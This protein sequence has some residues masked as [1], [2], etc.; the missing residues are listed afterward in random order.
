MEILQIV[1]DECGISLE[2]L[3]F[4]LSDTSDLKAHIAKGHIAMKDGK[5]YITQAGADELM[6]QTFDDVREYVKDT[7]DVS[8]VEAHEKWEMETAMKGGA[9]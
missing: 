2:Q 6:S 7:E 3:E 8:L 9:A 4:R 1:S 5:L